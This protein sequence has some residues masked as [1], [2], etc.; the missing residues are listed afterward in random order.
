MKRALVATACTGCLSL[1][2]PPPPECVAPRAIA[3]LN[4]SAREASPFLSPDRLE[5]WFSS[6]RGGNLHLVHAKRENLGETFSDTVDVSDLGITGSTFDP[7][8]ERDGLTMWFSK[9]DSA[10]GAEAQLYRARRSMRGTARF[11]MAEPVNLGA[12]QHPTMTADGLTL[13]F[14]RR[15]GGSHSIF[16]AARSS[17][18]DEF[19]TPEELTEI[20]GAELAA[21]NL[22]TPTI[23]PD[24]D[25]LVFSYSSTDAPPYRLYES[26]RLDGTFEPATVEVDTAAMIPGNSDEDPAFHAGGETIVFASNRGAPGASLDVFIACE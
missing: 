21:G 3:E 24:G 8:L 22:V 16:R 23:S 4:T 14:S 15:S 7:F 17:T 18:D 26:D 13:Y 1:G 12:G 6:D 10:A 25:R 5:I 19:D 9:L 20:R 2:E 11:A